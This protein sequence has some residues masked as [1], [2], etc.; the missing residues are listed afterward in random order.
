MLRTLDRLDD[1]D[2]QEAE[3]RTVSRTPVAE[4]SSACAR[5]RRASS[6]LTFT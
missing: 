6:R 1:V 2:L 3:P 4:P 5:I